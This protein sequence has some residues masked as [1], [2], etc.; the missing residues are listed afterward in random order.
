MQ[1][2]DSIYDAVKIIFEKCFKYVCKYILKYKKCTGDFMKK[3]TIYRIF[4]MSVRR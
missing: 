2:N 4:L 1:S 3:Q